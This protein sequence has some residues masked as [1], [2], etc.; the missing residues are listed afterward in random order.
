MKT[1]AVAIATIVCGLAAGK[2]MA[3]VPAA[4]LY[5]GN[6]C[7]PVQ[8]DSS[9]VDRSLYG[10]FNTSTTKETTVYCPIQTP[11]QSSGQLCV[12]VYDRNPS[13]NVSCS[14]SSLGADGNPAWTVTRT[15]A[16]SGT[17]AQ[18]LDFGFL[19]PI[20]TNMAMQCTIPRLTTSS[21]GSHVTSWYWAS[22]GGCQ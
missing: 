8:A 4:P 5:N 17:P 3:V 15:S 19:N 10:V 9:A 22:A 16:G 7:I 21:P 13:V 12:V 11:G 20:G 14:L 2:A 18:T 1:R 6:L